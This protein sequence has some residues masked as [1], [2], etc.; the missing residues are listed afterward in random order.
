MPRLQPGSRRPHFTRMRR[1]NFD[2]A[3]SLLAH[4]IQ[5]IERLAIRTVRTENSI[6]ILRACLTQV[7]RFSVGAASTSCVRVAR[8]EEL[9]HG[10]RCRAQQTS[11]LLKANETSVTN[12]SIRTI[13]TQLFLLL[14]SR[15]I[16]LIFTT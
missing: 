7:D 2:Q 3:C 1:R 16:Y 10:R 15:L 4:H 11:S 8:Q 9:S 12:G 6:V 14:Q 5:T 13:R